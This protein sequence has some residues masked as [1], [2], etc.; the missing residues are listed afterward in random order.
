MRMG[1]L[2]SLDR[3]GVG[4]RARATHWSGDG[5]RGK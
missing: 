5:Q 3:A 4:A 1:V 2:P